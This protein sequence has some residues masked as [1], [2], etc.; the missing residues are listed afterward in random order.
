MTWRAGHGA[1]SPARRARC[2]DLAIEHRPDVSVEQ[3]VAAIAR[4]REHDARGREACEKWGPGSSVSRVSVGA[5]GRELAVK[6]HRWRGLRGALSDLW[7]SSRAARARAGRERLSLCGVDSPALVAIAERRR[8]GLVRESFELSEFRGDAQPLAVALA[9]LAGDRA[10][11]RRLLARLGDLIGALHAAGI[12]HP[13]LK[14]SNLLVGGDGA[15]AL[16]DLDALVPPRRLTRRRRARAL[17]QLEAWARDLH[18]WL[19][20]GD[21]LCVLRAYFARVPASRGERRA[22]AAAADAWAARRLAG[23]ARR[24]RGVTGHYPLA[25]RAGGTKQARPPA[26]RA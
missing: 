21:R 12:D 1:P 14:P 17:G 19:L 5:D 6:L 24:D 16:L 4:H 7:R 26:A 23:W 9:A 20:P 18:P 3:V 25:P 15:L 22:L 13:D 10:R 8:A 2:G 11:R